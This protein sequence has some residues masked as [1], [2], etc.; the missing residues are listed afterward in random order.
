ME[1]FSS[2]IHWEI[3]TDKSSIFQQAM[4]DE[5]GGYGDVESANGSKKWR[6]KKRKKN[7]SWG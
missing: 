3:D 7:I 4:F 5:T 6:K 2:E 1:V